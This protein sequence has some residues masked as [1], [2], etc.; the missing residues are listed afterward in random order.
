MYF[1]RMPNFDIVALDADDTLWHNE[2]LFFETQARFRE[3]LGHNHD[4][5]SID[6]RLYATEKRNLKHFGYGIKGFMLS[7]IE[8]AIELT[9]GR[10]SGPQIQQIVDMGREMLD[11]PIELLDGVRETIEEISGSYRLMLLTKGD[12]FDQETKLARSGVGEQFSAIEIVSEKD[13]RTYEAVMRR[14]NVRPSHFVMVGNSLKSDI[15]PVLEVG[16]A[17]VHVPYHLTWI[18]EHVPE[19]QL[20]GKEFAQLQNIR[21]LPAWLGERG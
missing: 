19:E 16:G 8:T 2:R 20:A 11:S 3:L 18:H 12:L 4:A 21:E 13:A 9:E 7:M 1:R 6:Q 14:H 17:G 15:L 10:I 5:E